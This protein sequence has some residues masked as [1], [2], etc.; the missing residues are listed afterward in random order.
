MSASTRTGGREAT[1]GV[2]PGRIALSV[3]RPALPEPEGFKWRSLTDLAELESGHT[4]S[5]SKD[6]YWGGDIPWVGIRDATGNHGK[7]ICD[8]A[9]HVTQDGLDN[10]SARLLPKGTVCLSR[11]ASVGYVIEM[12]RPMATSQDFVNWVCGPELNNTY[13]RYILML[14]QD[15]VRRFAHGTTH[16]TM[17][18]PEAKALNVLVPERMHQDAIAEILGALDDKIAAND[19]ALSLLDDLSFAWFDARLELGCRLARVDEIAEFHNRRRVPLSSRVR[20]ARRGRV[21][22]YGAAG[23]VDFV[24]QA[25]FDQPLVLVGEDGTVVREDGRPVVQYIWGPAWVNNH[26]HVLTGRRISAELLR[27]AIQRSNVSHIVT[28]AVQPKIS[29]SNLKSLEVPMP[30]NLG[31]LDVRVQE[32]AAT[33]RS[34]TEENEQ[35]SATR[36]E[37]LPLLMSGK[38]RVMDAEDIAVGLV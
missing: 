20:E 23:R 14:E 19:L 15:S 22:Y 5:R 16:Q 8:T 31:Q 4:P 11:T 7:V 32:L 18:Y 28:G 35:L 36:E 37:L 33:T 34:L 13:L 29:M 6:H 30:T 38:V 24:D 2:I 26:A 27:I 9:D 1:K 3:G 10:S 21:P 17:Y 12:G 25:L